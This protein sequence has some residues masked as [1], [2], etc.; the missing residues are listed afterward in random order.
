MN[1]DTAID[2]FAALAHPTRLAVFQLLVREAPEGVPALQVAE[3]LDAK[4]S[5]LSGHLAIL[6]RAGLLTSSRHQREIRYAANLSAINTLVAFLLSDC[7]GGRVQNCR[8]ILTLL[9]R[10]A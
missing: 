2:A 7:C 1:Q 6:K 8:D 4:P 9:D 3:R 10:E 5:T